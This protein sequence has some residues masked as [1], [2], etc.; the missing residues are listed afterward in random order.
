M[1]NLLTITKRDVTFYVKNTP[2][3][4]NSW[5]ELDW[6][7]TY[8]TWENETFDIFDRYLDKDKTFIDIGG[9]IGTT[10]IY[11]SKK[12]KDVYVVEAD[13]CSI[14]RLTENCQLNCNNV[15]VINKAI[16]SKDCEEIYFGKNKIRSDSILNDSMS[17]IYED[18]DDRSRGD[19]YPIETITISSLI[20]QYNIHNISL[21]KVD[22]EGGEEFILD[23]LYFI[24]KELGI[25]LY[26]SFHYSWWKNKNLRR[27][28]FLNDEQIQAIV[29]NPFISI[30]F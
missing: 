22:I 2:R 28:S 15:T 16:Y 14:K 27:F 7:H 17:Q 10:C 5:N 1:S 26:I 20:K 21:I 11:A 13:K 25:K 12:S 6:W 23:D 19:C 29:D 8:G 4:D 9:W 30:L 24:K 18:D 3:D